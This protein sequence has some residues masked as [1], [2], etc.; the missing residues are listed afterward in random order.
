MYN[1]KDCISNAND[2]YNT[3]CE[4]D[5]KR[6]AFSYKYASVFATNLAFA[7]ELYLKAILM[8]EKQKLYIIHKL[9]DLY[10]QISSQ[11]KAKLETEFNRNEFGYILDQSLKKC[12]DTFTNFRYLYENSDKKN[13]YYSELGLIANSLRT[14]CK[15]EFDF[16]ID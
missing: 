6:L 2:F 12:S 15:T 14:I 5:N 11:T 13:L 8:S 7:C 1:I 3:A 4:I 16:I 9:D 10:N